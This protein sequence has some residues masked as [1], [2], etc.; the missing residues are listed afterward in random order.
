[1][2]CLKASVMHMFRNIHAEF[3]FS[4]LFP[5]FINFKFYKL[6]VWSG[7]GSQFLDAIASLVEWVGVW[8]GVSQSRKVNKP[9]FCLQPLLD[10]IVSLDY[11]VFRT[12]LKVW[13]F[14]FYMVPHISRDI[15]HNDSHQEHHEQILL[16]P[17]LLYVDMY[18]RPVSV[19][20]YVNM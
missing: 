3:N 20:K 6:L 2:L 16:S 4:I 17:L 14:R 18:G 9:F 11:S 5:I 15:L 19:C 13:S 12:S 1:M 8:E 10:D 7:G